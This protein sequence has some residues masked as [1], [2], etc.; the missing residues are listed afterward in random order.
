MIEQEFV[1]EIK[2][3]LR[4]ALA[5]IGV[6]IDFDAELDEGSIDTF[7]INGPDGGVWGAANVTP[8]PVPDNDPAG[9]FVWFDG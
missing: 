5:E 2:A 9:A 7:V 4:Q 1:E 3:E 8:F 6:H